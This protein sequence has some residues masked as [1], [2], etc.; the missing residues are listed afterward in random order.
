MAY[1]TPITVEE[2]VR[3]V[4]ERD[5]VHT[6]QLDFEHEQSLIAALKAGLLLPGLTEDGELALYRPLGGPDA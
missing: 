4:Q 6:I 2:A 5:H 3:R 1:I